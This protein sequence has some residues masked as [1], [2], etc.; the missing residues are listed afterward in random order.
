L[1][2][3]VAEFKKRK[4]E[5]DAIEASLRAEE[6]TLGTAQGDIA[7]IKDRW[8]PKLRELV[9]HVNEAFKNNF[10]A[11]GCAGEVGLCSC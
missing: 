8:L 5:I 6:A 3:Y 11:I 2:R 7:A 10:A 1:C 4:A 9:D